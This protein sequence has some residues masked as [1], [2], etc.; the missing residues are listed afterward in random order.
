MKCKHMHKD[1]PENAVCEDCWLKIQVV[2]RV[3]PL[4]EK[5]EF[6][7]TSDKVRN[8][9]AYKWIAEAV[10]KRRLRIKNQLRIHWNWLKKKNYEEV[11]KYIDTIDKKYFGEFK[12]AKE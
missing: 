5:I 2:E 9:Y 6:L 8:R 12:E 1:A 11:F 4:S 3:E 10:E 7:R